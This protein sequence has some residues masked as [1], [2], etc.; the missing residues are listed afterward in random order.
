MVACRAAVPWS[1]WGTA[2]LP[3]P[4]PRF[5]GWP[6]DRLQAHIDPWGMTGLYPR[7]MHALDSKG[8]KKVEKIE[9]ALD[10]A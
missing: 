4:I 1:G 5:L 2:G 7:L 3:R 10:R 6:A 8:Y 9:R